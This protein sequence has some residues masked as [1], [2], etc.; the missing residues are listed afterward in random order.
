MNRQTGTPDG[1]ETDRR[2]GRLTP[3]LARDSR[4][5]EKWPRVESEKKKNQEAVPGRVEHGGGRTE[6]EGDQ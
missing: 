4:G 5:S 1:L 2:T 6:E 3:P